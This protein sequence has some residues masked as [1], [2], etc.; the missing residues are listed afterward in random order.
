MES[1][2]YNSEGFAQR[3]PPPFASYF[4]YTQRIKR[5]ISLRTKSRLIKTAFTDYN[6]TTYDNTQF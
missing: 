5:P 6:A 4:L 3:Q 1:I 2:V